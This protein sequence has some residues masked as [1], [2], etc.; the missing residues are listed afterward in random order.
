MVADFAF[1]VHG[2]GDTVAVAVWDF[3]SGDAQAALLGPRARSHATVPEAIP[4]CDKTASA[5][6]AE[7]TSVTEYGEL[8]GLAFHP[9]IAGEMVHTHKIRD[10]KWQIA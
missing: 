7:G 6:I 4:R 3:E 8:I 1:L 10:A 2:L 9:I 5:D